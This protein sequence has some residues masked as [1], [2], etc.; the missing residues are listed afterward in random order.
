MN[1]VFPF[2]SFLIE[3]L[4]QKTKEEKEF[5]NYHQLTSDPIQ[6]F[7]GKKIKLMWEREEGMLLIRQCDSDD[8][9]I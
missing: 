5:I 9:D 4:S 8:D 7:L 1:V 3:K 2:G 6:S